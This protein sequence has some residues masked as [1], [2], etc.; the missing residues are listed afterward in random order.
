MLS[1][2]LLTT[3]EVKVCWLC[4]QSIVLDHHTTDERG[5][6][7]H[8]SCH[9]KQMLLQAATREAELWRQNLARGKTAH[10]RD[11]FV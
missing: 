6:S 3:N 5:L 10:D 9:E 1:T 11:Q 7:V 4:R 8:S 2:T